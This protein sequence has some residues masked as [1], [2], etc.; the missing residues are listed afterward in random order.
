[1]S[2]TREQI[3]LL[4]KLEHQYGVLSSAT[5]LT[6]S[7]VGDE[8]AEV[9]VGD[10]VTDAAATNSAVPAL[11]ED[12]AD[13]TDAVSDLQAI[14]QAND[15]D[16]TSR[17]ED[18]AVDLTNAREELTAAQGEIAAAF[19]TALQGLSDKVDTV[20]VGAGGSLILY[21]ASE[22][23][24]TAPPGSTWFQV[25]EVEGQPD[26]VVGQWQ[27]TGTDDA[28]VWTPRTLDSEVIANLDVAKLTA[29]QAAIAE[30]VAK[31]IAASTG[32]FQTANVANLFVT[33]EATLQQAVIEFLFAKV[34]QAKKITAEM[35]DV[36]SLFGI[37]LT[38]ATLRTAI[39]GEQ[40]IEIGSRTFDDV[41]GN[42]ITQSSIEFYSGATGETDPALTM[43]PGDGSVSFQS[44]Y[45]QVSIG[46]PLRR[47]AGGRNTSSTVNI[48]GRRVE[49]MEQVSTPQII[50]YG[51]G[52][53]L[54]DDSGPQMI[55][56]A[57]GYA[58][59]S[60]RPWRSRRMGLLVQLEGQVDRT[61]SGSIAANGTLGNVPAG[62]APTAPHSYFVPGQGSSYAT[63][64]VNTSG[65]ITVQAITGTTSYLILDNI[66]YVV[67]RNVVQ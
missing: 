41:D 31:K 36:A 37:V 16:L 59:N 44:A 56:P 22:P 25:V 11:Q 50:D 20:V 14:L 9:P 29:G 34:V 60:G 6:S 12:A 17:F 3:I 49:A 48:Q 62:W 23:Q 55:T 46:N 28:P 2:L 35:I 21:A 39:E 40:R 7:T 32:D 67:P 30:L 4:R 45:D 65:T 43:V 27:Q 58:S 18:A 66:S 8:G 24:G 5:Q 47:G 61:A 42:P 53:I 19:S 1:M 57:S 51:T 33:E 26:R 10:V 63:V 52:L 54:V 38:G 64:T 13:S 15:E